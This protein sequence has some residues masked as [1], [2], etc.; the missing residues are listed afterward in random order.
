MRSLSS[1]TCALIVAVVSPASAVMPDHFESPSIHAVELAPGGGLLYVTHT[2]DHRL[3]IFSLAGVVPETAAE[4]PVGLEP[5]A[6]RHRP[7]TEQV[8][9]VNHLSDSISIVDVPSQRVIDTITVGDEPTDVVFAGNPQRAF[10][11]VS[12]ED[13]ILVLDPEQPQA[14]GI[15]IPLP[16][17]DPRA[18]EV[19][20][21]GSTV[22]VA[23]HD[24]GN[25]TTAIH[26]EIVDALGGPPAP[27]PPVAA[28][29]PPAPRT[30]LIVK[31]DGAAWRDEAG[32]D[33]SPAIGY[34]MP[35]NDVL[36]IDASSLGVIDVWNGVG[37]HLFDLAVNPVSGHLLVTNQEAHNEV[38]FEPNL[39]GVFADTRV[40]ILSSGGQV[41]L[42]DLNPHVNRGLPGDPGTRALSVSM[43]LGLVVSDDGSRV[44]VS[45][46][47]S[48]KIAVLDDQG[49]TL[50]RIST[51]GGPAGMALAGDRL[52]VLERF[53][54][55]LAWIDL[56]TD[57]VQRISLGYDPTPADVRDGRAVFYDAANSRYG[58]LSCATCHLFGGMDNL[59]WDLGDPTGEMTPPPPAAD[60]LNQ[61]PDFHPMK[62]PMTT[63]SL[64]GLSGTEPLHWRGDREQLSD[65][66][67]AFT[68]LLGADA[69]LD[70]GEMALF[71]SFVF[72]LR[73]PPNPFRELDGSLPASLNGANPGNG[74]Q[75][76]LNGN[77]VGGLDCVS[78]HTLPTGENGLIIPA[79]ALQ[80][81]E[82]K[83][84]PQLRNM[85]EKTR[86]DDQAVSTVRGFGFTHDGAVDD[87]FTFLDFPGFTFQSDADQR[88]VEAFLLAFDTGT[89]PG[90]GAQWSATGT[91]DPAGEARLSVLQT[92][93]DLGQ[94]DLIAKGTD[95]GG[96]PMG[97]T[98]AG[99]QTWA[100]S[101]AADPLASTAQLLA[102]A[103]PG[104]E[105]TFTGVLEGAGTRIGIDRD[106]DGALDTDEVLLGGDPGD[107]LVQP[108][109]AVPTA[110][111]P[112]QGSLVALR[113]TGSI[114]ASTSA[115]LAFRAPAGLEAS[116]EVFDLRGRLVRGLYAG[117]LRTAEMP[118][119]WDLRDG[120]GRD[121]ASGVYL[122]RARAGTDA[123]SLKLAVVR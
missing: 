10:V 76:Y 49:S 62:G 79:N 67:G 92:A 89:H 58:D 48:A 56:Q 98:Y 26:F 103:G 37:T 39:N 78:C 22:Y 112:L 5:V 121:V 86:F 100:S 81:D 65:F 115:G 83:V 9:V 74:E 52:Y 54:N 123:V 118:L 63:Q 53:E 51:G 11:C 96:T 73:Y 82:A 64:Q 72:S 38:R 109:G 47:G 71:E 50:R 116:V 13:R 19:S 106:D 41:D 16:G 23:I 61:I 87:L 91:S 111:D 42:H 36:A 32:T 102:S 99:G 34:T 15:P 43:P 93:A 104:T 55:D 24:S 18:L 14:A 29:L 94:I 28:G 110:V 27:S 1:L 68:S 3:V 69:E 80:E 70:P 60:P 108:S 2:A 7:G 101:R 12:Q 84:V 57:A 114:P 122:V 85:Y 120:R 45:S 31:W 95:S 107:P 113:V 25:E 90:V 66:N 97:W 8:W 117:Q 21:D 75:L 105:I 17:S 20:P 44:Y 33:W 88:D 59:A 119:V 30:A 46:F 4:I 35:D 6:V 40:G 77:L